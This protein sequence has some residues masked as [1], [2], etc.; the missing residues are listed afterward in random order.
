MKRR[1]RPTRPSWYVWPFAIL[2]LF[3]VGLVAGSEQLAGILEAFI[4]WVV[5]G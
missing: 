4:G 1:R 2:L 3:L 5:E